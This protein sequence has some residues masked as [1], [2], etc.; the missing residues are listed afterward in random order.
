[1]VVRNGDQV[2]GCFRMTE[3]IWSIS[4]SNL[5]RESTMSFT[6]NYGGNQPEN[7]TSITTENVTS[8][9]DTE[10]CSEEGTWCV[11]VLKGDEYGKVIIKYANKEVY[12]DLPDKLDT[13]SNSNGSKLTLIYRNCFAY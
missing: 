9:K 3:L 11:V 7:T 4:S 5:K 8:N 2:R 6:V 13:I 12:R 1:M 10:V